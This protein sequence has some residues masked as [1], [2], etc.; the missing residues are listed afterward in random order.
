MQ[1]GLKSIKI[2]S[3]ESL[4]RAYH[5]LIPINAPMVIHIDQYDGRTLIIKAPLANNIN[6]QQSAFGGSLFLLSALVGWGL[7][8]LK[9]T[10]LNLTA[11]PV[12]AGGGVLPLFKSLS[13]NFSGSFHWPTPRRA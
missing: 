10:V 8:Q 9:L 5:D 12:I 3:V 7:L 13:K 11:N 1:T 6:H 4:Q 2:N